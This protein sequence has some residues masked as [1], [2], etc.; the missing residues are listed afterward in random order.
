MR[1]SLLFCI[2]KTARSSRDSKKAMLLLYHVHGVNISRSRSE[3]ITAA[4]PL[5]S[6]LQGKHITFAIANISRLCLNFIF[7]FRTVE[8][9]CPYDFASLPRRPEKIHSVAIKTFAPCKERRSFML[10]FFIFRS[11][12][13]DKKR[14]PKRTFFMFNFK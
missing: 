4:L 7:V 10:P 14:A 1:I 3:D 6:R 8:D 5:I 9:A 12:A 11:G 13:E 2:S